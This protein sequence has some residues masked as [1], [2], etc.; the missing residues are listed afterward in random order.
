MKKAIR[1]L[2]DRTYIMTALCMPPMLIML[3]VCDSL[4]VGM[5]ALI[6]GLLGMAMVPLLKWLDGKV[7]E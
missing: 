6:G 7:G 4:N 3:D 1:W 2:L 5:G